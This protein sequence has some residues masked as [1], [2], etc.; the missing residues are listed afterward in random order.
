[1]KNITCDKCGRY[2]KLDGKLSNLI[3]IENRVSIVVGR[4]SEH[5]FKKDLCEDCEKK[6]KSFLKFSLCGFME[7]KEED[8]SIKS[9]D[10]EAVEEKTTCKKEQ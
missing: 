4:K 7:L 3:I 2:N 1:M 9:I 5:V 8:G 6:L 10:G